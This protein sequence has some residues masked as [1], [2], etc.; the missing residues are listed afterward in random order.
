MD[1][2]AA[3][4]L[5]LPSASSKNSDGSGRSSSGVPQRGVI[6]HLMLHLQ[7]DLLADGGP[8]VR[9]KHP[10][11]ALESD[12]SSSED[13]TDDE[14]EVDEGDRVLV[15]EFGDE[16]SQIHLGTSRRF[17]DVA[18]ADRPRDRVGLDRA[19]IAPTVDKYG[20]WTPRPIRPVQ[21][22]LLLAGRQLAGLH[23]VD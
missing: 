1:L 20:P 4:D 6:R 19:R 7:H 10:A 9:G 15:I 14:D 23:R 21:V 3:S 12:E 11:V 13:K 2:G 8:D 18:G 16:G 17:L 22:E 5:K